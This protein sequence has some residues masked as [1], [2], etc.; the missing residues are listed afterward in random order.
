MTNPAKLPDPIG[1]IHF[2]DARSVLVRDPD[3]E[4]GKHSA[5]QS[6]FIVYTDTYKQTQAVINQWNEIM[7]AAA[8]K[9]KEILDSV[10]ETETTPDA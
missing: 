1:A 10:K 8:D 6:Q 2:S 5:V 7:Q 9:A 4:G 3:S